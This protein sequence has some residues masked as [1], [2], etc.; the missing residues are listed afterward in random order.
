MPELLDKGVAFWP[1]GEAS[2]NS[3]ADG[4]GSHN[5]AESG[6]TVAR[7]AGRS[8][9]TFAADF[10]GNNG[11][12]L[13]APDHANL[14]VGSGKSVTIAADVY[15]PDFSSVSALGNWAGLLEKMSSSYF[16]EYGLWLENGQFKFYVSSDGYYLDAD[17]LVVP[18]GYAWNKAAGWYR[19]E[20]VYDATAGKG[21]LRVY[22][23]Q[24]GRAEAFTATAPVGL[25]LTSN[26]DPV[27]LGYSGYGNAFPCRIQNAYLSVYAGAPLSRRALTFL[28]G[29]DDV[30]ALYAD[31]SDFTGAL[32]VDSERQLCGNVRSFPFEAH[33]TNPPTN[34]VAFANGTVRVHRAKYDIRATAESIEALWPN[35][36]SSGSGENYAG[37]AYSGA[38]GVRACCY[39]EGRESEIALFSI[40]G[41]TVAVYALANNAAATG[42][43]DILVRRGDR[44]VVQTEVT[45]TNGLC[46]LL[47]PEVASKEHSNTGGNYASAT[48]SLD[49]GPTGSGRA[50]GP[51]YLGGYHFDTV[52]PGVCVRGDS[53]SPVLREWLEEASPYRDIIWMH[54]GAA[55][56]AL[57]HLVVSGGDDL[58]TMLTRKVRRVFCQYSV[59]DLNGADAA[60][61]VRTNLY[62]MMGAW[63]DDYG[64]GLLTITTLLPALRTAARSSFI[65][66]IRALTSSSFAAAIGVTGV[67]LRTAD[68]TPLLENDSVN[69]DNVYIDEDDHR[70]LG[71]VIHLSEQGEEKYKNA[72]RDD[73]YA[74]ATDALPEAPEEPSSGGSGLTLRRIRA[75]AVASRRRRRR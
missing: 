72:T 23:H 71:D 54:F 33:Y 38:L 39:V 62:T 61:L 49:D 8:A 47:A 46:P 15:L 69:S 68:P 1:G 27:R 21:Y 36:I 44:L 67:D 18:M 37:D 42:V 64:R 24:T 32:V 14:R 65:A 34:T 17:S 25:T 6:G 19:F 41:S 4:F 40:N 51:A 48:V 74:A 73:L 29:S 9:S 28:Q 35:G 31:F 43:A 11:P 22:D 52:R 12:H 66:M 53:I 5:A 26:T 50:F 13:A 75:F 3:R 59:N 56:E 58:R 7:A 10:S 30:P 70:P 55:G 16:S 45:Y 60:A 57:H 20:G 2:G 63:L